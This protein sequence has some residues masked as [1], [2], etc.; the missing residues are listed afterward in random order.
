MIL[1]LVKMNYNKIVT[2]NCDLILRLLWNNQEW[3]SMNI[4]IIKLTKLSTDQTFFLHTINHESNF[5]WIKSSNPCVPY[6]KKILEN[7]P[8]SVASKGV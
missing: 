7:I 8:P 3:S 4:E 5:K 6:F 2:R 1:K